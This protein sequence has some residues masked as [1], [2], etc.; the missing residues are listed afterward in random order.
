[1]KL[2][3]KWIGEMLQTYA[4]NFYRYKGILAVKGMDQ[5]FVFQGV[6]DLFEAD[7]SDTLAWKEGDTRESK[8]VFIGKDL[9]K[10]ELEKGFKAC[11]AKPLRFNVGEIG[12]YR[13]MT[14]RKSGYLEKARLK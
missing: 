8:F 4:T 2:L 5:K 7:F 3:Q 14:T 6:H 12:V 1:M 10:D 11:I 9:K 13:L